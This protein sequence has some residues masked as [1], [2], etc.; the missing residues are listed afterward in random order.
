M[1]NVREKTNKTGLWLYPGDLSLFLAA[2]GDEDYSPHT[3][4]IMIGTELA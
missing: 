3:V 4:Y 1:L 2:V